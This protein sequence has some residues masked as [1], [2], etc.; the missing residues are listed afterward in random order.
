MNSAARSPRPKR[1]A[2]A[3]SAKVF[4][5]AAGL[6][7]TDALAAGILESVAR[8]PLRLAK[9][10]VLVPTRRARRS[11]ADAFLRQGGGRALLLPR[12]MALGDLDEDEILLTGGFTPNDSG[13]DAVAGDLAL[14]PALGGLR[15]QLMLARLVRGM[16][17]KTSP[18]QAANLALELAR[19]LDQVAT[20]RLTFDG[21]ERL[22]PEDFASHWQQTLTFLKVLTEQWPKVLAAEEALD[23][24]ERRNRLLDAQAET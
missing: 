10:T 12:M 20:E 7:F 11:L 24:A 3:D 21:L 8:D 16:D 18:D 6:P 14:P 9:V 23:A 15:R 13:L 2:T 4:I 1:P 5:I 17:E 22:A 19:L